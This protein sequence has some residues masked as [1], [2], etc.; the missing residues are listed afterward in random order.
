MSPFTHNFEVNGFFLNPFLQGATT[1][2]LSIMFYLVGVIYGRHTGF[3]L[4]IMSIFLHISSGLFLF[5]VFDSLQ[6]AE[7]MCRLR[8]HKFIRNFIFVFLGF[9]VLGFLVYYIKAI[10]MGSWS[11]TKYYLESRAANHFLL[12]FQITVVTKILFIAMAIFWIAVGFMGN[13][14]KSVYIL[15]TGM[16]LTVLLSKQT[17]VNYGIESFLGIILLILYKGNT[18]IIRLIIWLESISWLL[19]LTQVFESNRWLTPIILILPGTR[20]VSFFNLF[21]ILLISHWIFINIKIKFPTKVF[22]YFQFRKI[23]PLCMSIAGILSLLVCFIVFENTQK[24]FFNLSTQVSA[25]KLPPSNPLDP[26]TLAIDVETVGW[27]EFSDRSIFVDNYVFWGNLEEYE[28]RTKLSERIKNQYFK[29]N[30]TL[31]SLRI[32]LKNSGYSRG[33]ILAVKDG[34]QLASSG[35]ACNMHHHLSLCSAGT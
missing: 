31:K 13:T 15:S 14:N 16:I 3:F 35:F 24:N 23:I 25:M 27:R 1:S 30:L 12:S 21:L 11:G 8:A 6:C 26:P 33:L 7:W 19:L 34:R 32:M 9:L 18:K 5:I 4:K 20:L 17:F 29:K 22:K 28:S 10:Q 2:N